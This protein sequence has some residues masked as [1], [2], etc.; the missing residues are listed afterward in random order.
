MIM[1]Q[2]FDQ[3]TTELKAAKETVAKID[4]RCNNLSCSMNS[5]QEENTSLKRSQKQVHEK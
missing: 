3:Q 2:S 4:K 1:G 5:L